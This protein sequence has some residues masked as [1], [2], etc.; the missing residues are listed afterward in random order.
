MTRDVVAIELEKS[1]IGV[2]HGPSTFV[3][4]KQERNQE[5]RKNQSPQ[6]SFHNPNIQPTFDDINNSFCFLLQFIHQGSRIMTTSARR[7]GQAYRQIYRQACYFCFI[8][9]LVMLSMAQKHLASAFTRPP[10]LSRALFTGFREIERSPFGIPNSRRLSGLKAAKLKNNYVRSLVVHGPPDFSPKKIAK[11]QRPFKLMIVESPSKCKTI[12]KILQ[13]YVEKQKLEH[14]YVVTSCMGHIRNIPQQKQHKNQIVAGIDIENAYRPTYTILPEKE[15]LVH[16]LKELSNKAQQII[17]ATDDDREG[18]AMAWH[19][20][21]VL[22]DG[23]MDGTARQLPPS[24][25]RFTEITQKAIIRSIESPEPSLRDNLVQAQ[26]TRRILDRLAGFTVSPVLWKKIAPGLSAGR[27]QSVGMALIV[28]RER[29]RLLFQE[30]EYWDIEANFSAMKSS[31]EGQLVSV[32]GTQVASGGTDFEPRKTDTLTESSSHKLHFKSKAAQMLAKTLVDD[33]WTWKVANV[34]AT[35]RKLNP[36]APFITSTLQQEANTRLGLSVSSTMQTAQQLYENGFISYMRTDSNHLSD[37]AKDAIK[38]EITNDYGGPD[39]YQAGNYRSKKKKNSKGGDKPDP[40]AAH[41]AIRPAIQANGRFTKPS[42]LPSQYDGATRELYEIVYQR[43]IGSH[44]PPQ[45]SNQTSIRILGEN[46]DASVLFR[47]SGSVVIIPGFSAVYSRPKKEEPKLPSLREGETIGCTLATPLIHITQP[48]SRFTEASFVQE[49]EALGVGRPSTYA[50]TVQILRDRAYVGSPSKSDSGGR[51]SAK[52]VSGPAISAQRAAGG[53]EFTGSRSARGPMVPSLTAFVVTSLL[54]KHCNMYVD[55]SFTARMEE[56]LDQIANAVESVSEDERVSY[57]DE[58]FQGEGGLASQIGRINDLVDAEDARRARLPSLLHVSSSTDDEIGLFVGPWG[59]YVKKLGSTPN[60]VEK[61]PTAQLPAGMASD[62]STITLQSLKSVLA[63]KEENGLILGTHPDD[64]RNIRLKVGRFGAFLQMGEDDDETT[65]THTLPASIRNMRTIN[66]DESSAEGCSLN[67]MLGISLEDAIKFVNL[68]RTVCTLDDS[69]IVA[70]IG[71]YGPYLK[72]N[73]TFITL[74][75]KDGDV[76]TIEPEAAEEVVREGMKQK[77]SKCRSTS[78]SETHMDSLI[79]LCR[80][81]G[82]GAGVLVEVGEKEGSKVTVKSGRF[83][84][85]INW[86]KVNAK[87]PVEYIED[88]SEL[89]LDEAWKLIEEKAGQQPKSKT[90]RKQASAIELPPAPKRSLTA[91]LHFCAE[92]R[93]E[94]SSR[95]KSLG[96]ISKELARLWG[97]TS[98]DDRKPYDELA[99]SGKGAYEEAKQKWAAECQEILKKEGSA[100]NVKQN[101]VKK[102]AKGTSGPKRPLSAYLFFC[103]D[104]RADVSKECSTLGETSKELARLWALTSPIARKPYEKLAANDKE[105]Y[106]MEKLEGAPVKQ[107]AKMKNGTSPTKKKKTATKKKRGPSA[108][109]LFCAEHRGGI[110]DEKGNKLPL[111]ETTKRLAKMWGECDEKDRE[112][113]TAEALKQKSLLV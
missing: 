84:P 4:P 106:E 105:R 40:Q 98:Q 42:D 107:Q 37:D 52:V 71:P 50:G 58:F 21:Q 23:S 79:F 29:E 102:A 67:N 92:K 1:Q 90:S 76:L 31:F 81:K 85:Y 69:P 104:K 2:L 59:P 7:P 36:P 26:E 91:Y 68:P 39:F 20:L 103:G 99:K 51:G 93:P 15:Q 64:N 12:C 11:G 49:L 38:T 22:L 111:G 9:L 16:D 101:R 78:R 57:L 24:R 100:P 82:L 14:D 41:E 27:V 28:Q 46:D 73:N 43:T 70:A 113:F 63:T 60:G 97:E 61:S 45:V 83:G 72:Y 86:R 32:N 44:M 53:E 13:E 94:V 87:L 89:P 48:P 75:A 80:P 56:R 66:V 65:T 74:K 96:S 108:Y 8:A 17:L 62:L 33:D 3:G 109:M 35:E 6:S 5:P 25:V 110:V 95:V 77:S 112:R 34:T 54:E 19:L 10:R 55:P 18:E 88:A 47:T 30:T